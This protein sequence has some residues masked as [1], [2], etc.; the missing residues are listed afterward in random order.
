MIIAGPS[1]TLTS[2]T[3]V[4]SLVMGT[5]SSW[6]AVSFFCGHAA[7]AIAFTY[8]LQIS[9][10]LSIL[11]L[12]ERRTAKAEKARN[13]LVPL[14]PGTTSTTTG[15]ASEAPTPSVTE[16]DQT[17]STET[18]DPEQPS[19]PTATEPDQTASTETEDPEQPPAPRPKRSGT[20]DTISSVKTTDSEP[21]SETG[22]TQRHHHWTNYDVWKISRIYRAEE[23]KRRASW[24]LITGFYRNIVMVTPVRVFI[25]RTSC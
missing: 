14:R 24:K 2:I 19:A 25:V 7:L 9:F 5:L 3:S 20:T 21:S 11:Y 18:S 4:A 17:A 12:Y 1:I 13:T 6:P 22:T 16:P 10:F 8:L 23:V 15:D